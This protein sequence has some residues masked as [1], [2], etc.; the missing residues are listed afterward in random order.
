V[1][2]EHPD[3][4]YVRRKRRFPARS[5][6]RGRTAG[7][8][9]VTGEH[10]ITVLEVLVLAG[11][12]LCGA[13][14][15]CFLSAG[16]GQQEGVVPA[17]LL[18]EGTAMQVVGDVDGLAASDT[19]VEGI[20]V[21]FPEQNPRALGACLLTVSPVVGAWEGIDMDRVRISLSSQG[22][23]RPLTFLPAGPMDG[24]SWTIASRSHFLPFHAADEDR[25]L[26]PNEQ[27]GLLIV[28][29]SPLEPREQFTL[30]IAPLEGGVPLTVTR[31]VPARVTPVMDLDG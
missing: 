22:R 20:P 12:I 14:A 16:S 24:S 9:G 6:S 19:T 15:V 11:L 18:M 25:I 8:P 1:P 31:I 30:T 28:A 29:P 4:G 5:G 3:P 23:T 13:G 17:A 21:R 7:R 2:A 10:G 27:F 26:E